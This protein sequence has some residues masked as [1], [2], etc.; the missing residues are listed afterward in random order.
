M[1]DVELW[2]DSAGRENAGRAYQSLADEHVTHTSAIRDQM[3]GDLPIPHEDAGRP[4]AELLTRLLE[5]SEDVGRQLGFSGAGQVLM[6]RGNE[7]AEQAV[8]Y[9]VGRVP[10]GTEG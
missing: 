2:H 1:P 6:A 3:S 9:A 8:T 10:A 4:Y 5:R 7:Q